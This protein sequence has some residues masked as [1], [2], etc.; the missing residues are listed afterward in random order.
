M[1][2]GAVTWIN[3]MWCSDVDKCRGRRWAVVDRQTD[4]QTDSETVGTKKRK[5]NFLTASKK[6]V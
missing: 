1:E 2:C 5:R 4:R 6:D 3:G